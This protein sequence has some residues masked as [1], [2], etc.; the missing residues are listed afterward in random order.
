MKYNPGFFICIERYTDLRLFST[1]TFAAVVAQ[2]VKAIGYWVSDWNILRSSPS[3]A[4][5][6]LLSH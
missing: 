3:I 5:F 2:M 4:K 1:Y 6:P